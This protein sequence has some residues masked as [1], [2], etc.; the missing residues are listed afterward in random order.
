MFS[1]VL[2]LGGWDPE[3]RRRMGQA[4]DWLRG[5]CLDQGFG[6]FDLGQSF[7]KLGMWAD[8]RLQLSK[9]GTSVLG[10]KLSGLVTRALN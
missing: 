7:E 2:P 10:S 6:Y 8:D 9:W 1:S 4:N 5:W 3:R